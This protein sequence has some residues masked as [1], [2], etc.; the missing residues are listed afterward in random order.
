MT[1]V[2]FRTCLAVLAGLILA[3]TGAWASGEEEQPAAA[4]EKE[5]VLD[6]TTGEMVTAPE[7]GGT[8][9][10]AVQRPPPHPDVCCGS[11]ASRGADGVLEKL[12]IVNWGIDR[13]EYDI[14]GAFNYVPISALTG[15]LAESW[16][17]PDALT[18]VF[19][20]RPGVRWHDK[21]PMNGRELTAEDVVF[22]FHRISGTGSGFTEP[23]AGYAGILKSIPFDSITAT[24]QDTVVFKLTQP[25][26]LALL[27][28][29]VEWGAWIYPPEVIREHGDLT[30]WRNLVGTGP[31]MLTDWLDGSSITHTR[32]PDYWG[33]DEKYPNNRLPYFDQLSG[34]I[35]PEPATILAALRS[36]QLDYVGLSGVAEF[37]SLTEQ[38]S[39]ARTNPEI[40]LYPWSI[41][42]L[43]AIAFYR[44]TEDSP[45]ASYSGDN[46]P[47]DDVRVRQAMQMALDH[48]TVHDTYFRGLSKWQP[49]G[50]IGE[51]IVGYNTPFEEWPEEVKKSYTYDPEGAEKLL[52]EAGY[53][54]GADGIRLK[55]TMTVFEFAIDYFELV[56]GYWKE[57]GVD[58]DVSIPP[59]GAYGGMV[60]EAKY[61]DMVSWAAAV[62]YLAPVEPIG[63]YYSGATWNPPHYNDPEYDR[64]FEA[65]RDA[66]TV[67]Q[68]QRAVKAADMYYIRNHIAI[69]GPV[70]P[71]FNAVQPWVSGY[72]GEATL[73]G[74]DRILV[75]SRLWFDHDLMKEM[76]Q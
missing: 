32:N 38:E 73:G 10:F 62:Q 57:I 64:L 56:A 3:A 65:V 25:N 29:L 17:L 7:Y 11:G 16:E 43:N 24:D 30:D 28:I 53:P 8:M 14:T 46:R 18:Y 42:T 58:V 13:N 12:G 70:V 60:R 27:S 37:I 63:Y 52:N 59:A 6:P 48:E 40:A 35:M 5:M 9:T 21:A 45:S 54:P 47:F 61:G 50:L 33:F 36:G 44:G 34:L 31:Y 74:D 1:H 69:W 2:M 15:R 66:T 68:Q 26:P 55:A 23:P 75:F 67:E 71:N 41:R 4:M 51:A 19:N 49:Q 39:L 22:S 20:L 72:N 76:G